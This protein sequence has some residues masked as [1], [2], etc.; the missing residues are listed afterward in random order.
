MTSYDGV[1]ITYDEIGNPLTY[2]N[3]WSY[4][5]TWRG[6]QLVGATKGSKNIT[7]VYNDDG[8]RTGKTVNGVEHSY[9]LAGDLIMAEAWGDKLLVYIY[10]AS[11]SPI[12][13]MYR[14]TSYAEDVWDI[15]WYEKN[16]QG[17]IVAVYNSSG[18]KVATYTYENAW[19]DHLVSYTS[20]TAAQYNPFRYRGYYYD[21]D[22]GM[23]YLQSRYYDPATAR[24]IN[25]DDIS[26]ITAT[27]AALTDKNLFA[28]CDNNPVVRID[29]GGKVWN[30]LVG[31]IVG[32]SGSALVASMQNKKGKEF[33][34]HVA[35]GAVSGF[36]GGFAIDIAS[37]FTVSALGRI[38]VGA[39]SNTFASGV[40]Y[41][42]E[43]SVA[44]NQFQ[45]T[46]FMIDCIFG[47]MI[48]S[49][50]GVI[51]GSHKSM[52]ESVTS[53]AGKKALERGITFTYA[54]AKTSAKEISNLGKSLVEETLTSFF[55]WL[56]ESSVKY[57]IGD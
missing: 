5:F 35:S 28:Y 52:I 8:I 47:G 44:G 56:F 33:W 38:G 2:Y 11:G 50:L 27:P 24:F 20:T 6:R 17:D 57:F 22:L 13:M 3:G 21:T 48:G 49:L 30:W 39:F 55:S 12:G 14:T 41:A 10:D 46:S 29:Q 53:S 9:Y 51:D 15:Y 45:V 16:L 26:I 37:F 7:F 42:V 54:L 31:T 40:S 4:S 32:V 36:L 34:A 19:G 25:V 23:Y 43:C 18:T 1:T